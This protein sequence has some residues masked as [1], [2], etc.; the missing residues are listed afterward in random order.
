MS[1]AWLHQ[2]RLADVLCLTETH[3]S[4]SSVSPDFQLEGYTF[5]G[6]NR[7]VSYTNRRDLAK[8]D[9]GGVATYCRNSLQAREHRYLQNVTDLEFTMIRV[10]TPGQALIATVYRPPSYHLGMFLANVKSLLDALYILNCQIIVICGDFNEDLLSSGKKAINELF[11]SRGYSQLISA[12]TTEKQTV[13]FN[14]A[15]CTLTTVTTIL[16]IVCLLCSWWSSGAHS[17]THCVSS[18][19]FVFTPRVMKQGAFK[20]LVL[21]ISFNKCF[22]GLLLSEYYSRCTIC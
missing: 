3:L 6:R 2:L 10:E 5:F 18:F 13:V 14:Q 17:W 20:T 15:Y 7:H 1:S 16:C 4:G 19:L 12:P 21:T 9:G 22:R 11:K 8:K